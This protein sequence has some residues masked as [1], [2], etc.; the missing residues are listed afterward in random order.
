ML[1]KLTQ[2]MT[3][4]VEKPC[5]LEA[6]L[7]KRVDELKAGCMVDGSSFIEPAAIA[8]ERINIAKA[9]SYP[10]LQPERIREILNSSPELSSI[11]MAMIVGAA[12][13]S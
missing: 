6:S 8:A 7:I 4:G 5:Y 12:I 2:K 11:P 3:D 1:V 10:G 13:F 9:L